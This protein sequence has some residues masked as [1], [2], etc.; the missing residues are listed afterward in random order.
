MLLKIELSEITPFFYNNFFGF[1]GISLLSPPGYAL[2]WNSGKGGKLFHDHQKYFQVIYLEITHFAI[3]TQILNHRWVYLD[4]SIK[5]SGWFKTYF[6]SYSHNTTRFIYHLGYN[7]IFISFSSISIFRCRALTAC[8]RSLWSHI[9]KLFT[10]F[11]N[12][13]YCGSYFFKTSSR[14]STWTPGFMSTI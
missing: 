7:W 6:Q 8:Y 13:C 5:L 4:N 10:V 9:L 11:K 1:W 12:T 3:E 14:L 2:A